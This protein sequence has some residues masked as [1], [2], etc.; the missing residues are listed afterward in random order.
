MPTCC[1]ALLTF[2]DILVDGPYMKD[3][4]DLSLTF[5]GSSNQRIIDVPKSIVEGKVVL[6]DIQLTEIVEN[7]GRVC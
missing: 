3:L 1:K 7:D 5:R 4:R 2:T 6:H